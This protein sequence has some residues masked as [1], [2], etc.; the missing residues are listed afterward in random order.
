MSLSIRARLTL[1]YSAVVIVVLT[2]FTVAVSVAQ[3][4]LGV[5]HLDSEMRR[6]SVTVEGV[7]RMEFAERRTLEMAAV[8]TSVEVVAP[9][10]SLRLERAR[11]DAAGPVGTASCGAALVSRL[12]W[13]R[14]ADRDVRVAVRVHASVAP[15]DIRPAG[16]R[17]D[18]RG[19][20]RRRLCS[21]KPK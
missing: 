9:D 18:G 11:R 19:A 7:F 6:L 21:V 16:V 4:R 8:E 5:T 3:R 13:T 14:R 10:Y 15:H 1:W 2:A 20:S 12:G 17:G